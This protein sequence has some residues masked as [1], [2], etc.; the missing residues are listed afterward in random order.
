[1]FKMLNEFNNK[2]SLFQ[3]NQHF[4]WI[5]RRCILE[6][7]QQCPSQ[8]HIFNTLHS[9]FPPLKPIK[10]FCFKINRI[11][12]HLFLFW[13]VVDRKSTAQH[14]KSTHKNI[15]WKNTE[16]P[17]TS[18][19][20]IYDLVGVHERQHHH[21]HADYCFIAQSMHT[22]PSLSH[23]TNADS[24]DE[25]YPSSSLNFQYVTFVSLP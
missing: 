18:S 8:H 15:H 16:P 10:Y 3:A 5:L 25:S 2:M 20:L 7:T 11:C 13:N 1:M 4:I 22:T 17:N 14:D 12:K 6:T 24:P 21:H 19:S 9:S 23:P